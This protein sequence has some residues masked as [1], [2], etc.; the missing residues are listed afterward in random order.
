MPTN[1]NRGEIEKSRR[2]TIN[3]QRRSCTVVY[4][5]EFPLFSP[6]FI[7][8]F[9][10]LTPRPPVARALPQFGTHLV[11][12]QRLD[13]TSNVRPRY[14]VIVITV[15][16]SAFCT[17]RHRSKTHNFVNAKGIYND[18][19]SILRVFYRAFTCTQCFFLCYLMFI[20]IIIV[21]II[22]VVEVFNGVCIALCE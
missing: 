22:T 11:V 8:R 9:L 6:L 18:S 12:Y 1:Q 5:D 13:V 21:V 14:R 7:C 3:A 16:R 4:L 19:Q 17:I 20:N 2:S 15:G 10:S